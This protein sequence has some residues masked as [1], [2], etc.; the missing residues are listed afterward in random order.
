MLRH[1]IRQARIDLAAA[2]R[3]A[4][5]FGLNEGIDNHFTLMLPGSKDRFLLNPFGLH[6][7]E[8]TASN[9]LVV[10]AKGSV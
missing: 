2:Y 1:N 10:D 3:L 5:R 6:W 8:V 9:L 4:N 7:S